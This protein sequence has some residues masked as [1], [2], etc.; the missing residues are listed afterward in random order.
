MAAL[1][2]PEGLEVSED[3]RD[4]GSQKCHVL[5]CPREFSRQIDLLIRL[6]FCMRVMTLCKTAV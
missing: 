4:D 1:L 5:K 6:D 3:K 2:F